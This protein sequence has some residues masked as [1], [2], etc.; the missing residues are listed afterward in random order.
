LTPIGVVLFATSAPANPP[1]LQT[2][3]SHA[4]LQTLEKLVNIAQQ[5]S[6][7]IKEAKAELGVSAWGDSVALEI[8]PSYSVGTFVEEGDRRQNYLTYY[9]EFLEPNPSGN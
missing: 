1:T 5:N 3:L 6:G 2:D 9:N 4:H 8:T 7:A